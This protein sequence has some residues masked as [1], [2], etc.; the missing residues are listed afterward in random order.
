MM[1]IFHAGLFSSSHSTFPLPDQLYKNGARGSTC[2]AGASARE[3]TWFFILF[4]DFLV[5]KFVCC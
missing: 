3:Q 4:R 5:G 2:G 1:E